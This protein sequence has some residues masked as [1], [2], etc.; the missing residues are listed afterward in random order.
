ME[1]KIDDTVMYGNCDICKVE[2]IRNEKFSDEEQLYYVLKPVYDE[3]STIYCPVDSEMIKLRHLLT[4]EE[5]NELIASMPDTETEWI[6][7]DQERKQRFND[8][9]RNGDHRQLVKLL[10]TL[11]QN[12]EMK[13]QE[14]KKFYAADER[15]MKEAEKI[16]HG[17]IAYV[18]DI[19]LEEVVPY[20]TGKLTD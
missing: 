9:L 15:V 14:G 18:L 20:I 6:E 11:Y 17:E 8:L 16:V 7:N 1:F 4:R 19:S 2:D 13:Q 12:R 3:R 5:V 10:K